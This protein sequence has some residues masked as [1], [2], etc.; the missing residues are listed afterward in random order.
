VN[1]HATFTLPFLVKGHSTEDSHVLVCL[2]TPAGLLSLG[3]TVSYT[4]KSTLDPSATSSTR[5]T[6]GMPLMRTTPIPNIIFD[7]HL[8]TL[9]MSELKVLLLIVRQTLGWKVGPGKRKARDWMS[10]S[11]IQK[12]TGLSERAISTAIDSL[13]AMGLIQVTA[14]RGHLLHDAR[15]RQGHTKLY[16]GL[17]RELLQKLRRTSAKNT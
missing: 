14:P 13:V 2:R 6:R 9:K 5:Y 15:A 8:A 12:R 4:P 3:E 17:H 11:Y 1:F 16:Y 10:R 7:T